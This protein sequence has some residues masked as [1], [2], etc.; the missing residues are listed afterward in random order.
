MYDINQKMHMKAIE[1]MKRDVSSRSGKR[2][3]KIHVQEIV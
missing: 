2:E 1:K 3:I